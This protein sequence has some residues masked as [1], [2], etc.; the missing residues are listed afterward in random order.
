MKLLFKS[1]LCLFA[2]VSTALVVNQFTSASTVGVNEYSIGPRNV[3][4]SDTASVC[5]LDGV[6]PCQ[7]LLGGVDVTGWIW[8]TEQQAR[9]IANDYVPILATAQYVAGPAYVTQAAQLIGVWGHTYYQ[10]STYQYTELTEGWTS[11]QNVVFGAHWQSPMLDSYIGFST[12]EDGYSATRGSLFWRPVGSV[13]TT[14]TTTTTTTVA[15]TTTTTVAPT[16]TTT[17]PTITVVTVPESTTTTIKPSG[18]NRNKCRRSCS[19]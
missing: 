14:T 4:W 13:V 17:Q 16:T 10:S 7:G 5:P 11:N 12:V 2:L 8:A 18:K 19:N 15:P 6:T 1:F 9:D 3:S